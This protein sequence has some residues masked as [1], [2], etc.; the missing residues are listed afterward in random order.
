MDA[1]AGWIDAWAGWMPGLDGCLGWMEELP[2]RLMPW[3]DGC[4]GWMEELPGRLM[5]WLDGCLGW[6]DAWA[7]WMSCL[8]GMRCLGGR[9]Q[10]SA[11]NRDRS[12]ARQEEERREQ[13]NEASRLLFTMSAASVHVACRGRMIPSRL[14]FYM[15]HIDVHHVVDGDIIHCPQFGR[16]ER[17]ASN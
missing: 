9:C 2:G 1:W 4:L 12:L 10:L 3:L 17:K 13:R 6:M 15:D 14:P 7:G 16:P 11:E 8:G 5:P